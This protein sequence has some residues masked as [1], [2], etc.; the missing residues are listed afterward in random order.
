[1]LDKRESI[2]RVQLT[3]LGLTAT[4]S[5]AGKAA[6]APVELVAD[7]KGKSHLVLLSAVLTTLQVNER[8]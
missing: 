3:P 1:M 6:G 5:G 2:E 4:R 8:G 7:C